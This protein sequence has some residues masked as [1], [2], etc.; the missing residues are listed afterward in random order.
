VFTNIK[1]LYNPDETSY[2]FYVQLFEQY[3]IMPPFGTNPISS[4]VSKYVVGRFIWPSYLYSLR[5]LTQCEPYY[6]HLV[7]ILFIALLASVTMGFL[8]EV[9][10][11]ED[12]RTV[13]VITM[14]IMLSPIVFPWSATAFLDL[15]QSYFILA[16]LYFTLRS[17]RY[18]SDGTLKISLLK[19]LIGF[20]YFFYSAL[21]KANILTLAIVIIILIIELNRYR[22]HLSRASAFVLRVLTIV[23]TSIAVAYVVIDFARFVSWYFFGNWNLANTLRKY[24]IFEVSVIE[25]LLGA[26]IEFPWDRYTVF[27]YSWRQWLDFLDFALAPEALTVIV[28]SI[29]LVMP[30]LMVLIREFRK[31]CML[32]ARTL[33]Y[34]TYISFWFYF[35]LQIGKN[36]LYDLSRF[37]LHIYVLIMIISWALFYRLLEERDRAKL[38]VVSV[39]ALVVV[40][41]NKFV[42]LEFGGTKFFF[43]MLRYKYPIILLLSETAILMILLLLLHQRFNGWKKVFYVSLLV[44]IVPTMIFNNAVFSNS[45]LFTSTGLSAVGQYLEGIGNGVGKKVVV[46]NAYI[47]L[48]NYLDLDK[49]VP[50]PPP[51]SELEFED[52]LKFLPNG[53]ILVLTDDPRI[54][55]YEYANAYIKKYVGQDFIPIEYVGPSKKL[56]EPRLEITVGNISRK[57]VVVNGSIVE[58][59][60]GMGISLDGGG[61]NIAVYNYSLGDEYTIEILFRVDE[62][63]SDFGLYP[64]YVPR[65]GGQPVTKSLLAKRYGGYVEIMILVTSRGQVVVYADNKDDKP[66]FQITTRE[67]VIKRG[68]WFHLV[69]TV[70]NSEARLYINGILVGKS[71]VTGRNMVLA[72]V[73]IKNEPLYIGSDGT[74]DFKPWRY[75]KATIQFVRIYDRL[76]KPEEIMTVYEH[77]E[78]VNQINFGGYRYTIYVKQETMAGNET[79]TGETNS[80]RLLGAYMHTN[81]TCI[82]YVES[83]APSKYI[84]STI[85]FSEVLNIDEENKILHFPYLYNNDMD[86]R[87][88]ESVY[89]CSFSM[90]IN[91]RGD[92]IAFHVNKSMN[93]GE[94]LVY[95]TVLLILLVLIIAEPKLRIIF[96]VPL[97][98]VRIE[99]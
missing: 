85:R 76:V 58:T 89:V 92:V 13:L 86:S 87:I 12:L 93:L 73:G 10:R 98:R 75:L 16:S 60:W 20:I 97:K 46:S 4:E 19:L 50:I 29:F 54:S 69:L 55:W 7:A 74:F 80:L 48:R 11:I 8:Y 72:E 37:G 67:G 82:M 64:K 40:T 15:P 84:I 42:L 62:D 91:Q 78:R 61:Q 45:Y 59:P 44:L 36:Q 24:L 90:I 9:L 23:I 99:N 31:G 41:I 81:E 14:L 33:I 32:Q 95:H 49:F 28:S 79:P 57:V 3:K 77:L 34:A 88:K 38:A 96:A 35:I 43:D 39:V 51:I 6:L 63:P 66:R 2:V 27:S 18:E 47:Y 17:V 1:R 25:N 52:F 22:Q 94:L 30:L 65:V 5:V 53:S 56:G 68:E 21:F 26:F 70:D 83:K 71:N